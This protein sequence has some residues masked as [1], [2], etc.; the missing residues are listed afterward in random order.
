MKLQG[1]TTGNIKHTLTIPVQ[2]GDANMM[3][4]YVSLINLGKRL[5]LAELT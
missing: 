2:R 4:F 5:A 1:T 3:H